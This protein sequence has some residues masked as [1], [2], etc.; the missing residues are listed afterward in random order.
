MTLNACEQAFKVTNIHMNLY[1]DIVLL[2][3]YVFDILQ[4]ETSECHLKV[5]GNGVSRY[6]AYIRR[7]ISSLL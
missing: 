3:L 1:Y 4:T 7:S 6:I 5:S 2:P